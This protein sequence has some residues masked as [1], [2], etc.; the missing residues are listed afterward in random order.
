MVTKAADWDDICM[1]TISKLY[2][3]K[4][5]KAEFMNYARGSVNGEATDQAA[6]ADFLSGPK[7]GLPADLAKILSENKGNDLYAFV[8]KYV[9]QF[10]W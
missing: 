7:I 10:L 5:L 6:F 9:C 2:N 8:G 3:D 4:A 1:S